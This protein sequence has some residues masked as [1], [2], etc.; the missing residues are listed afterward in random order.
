[1][2]RN[3]VN[4]RLLT[5]LNYLV[6]HECEVKAAFFTEFTKLLV[7]VPKNDVEKLKLVRQTFKNEKPAHADIAE[8]DLQT[9]ILITM[10]YQHY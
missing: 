2:N 3:F 5:V 10:R 7:Y 1:M 4:T 9:D 6:I 8:A